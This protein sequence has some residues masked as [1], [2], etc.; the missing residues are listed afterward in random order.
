MEVNYHHIKLL[1]KDM[2]GDMSGVHTRQ[3]K[4]HFMLFGQM[5]P[6]FKHTCRLQKYMYVFNKCMQI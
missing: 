3:R 1:Y 6:H 4:L 5:D 2:T